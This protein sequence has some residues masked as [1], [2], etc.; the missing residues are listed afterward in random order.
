MAARTSRYPGSDT[1]GVPASLTSTTRAPCRNLATRSSRLEPSL[2][3]CSE[4]SGRCTPSC[5]NRPAV[6]RVSSAAIT[7]AAASASRA[8]GERSP[9]LP[10]GVATTSIRPGGLTIIS[11]AI[12]RVLQGIQK[13]APP[14]PDRAT[15]S[16]SPAPQTASGRLGLAAASL[17]ALLVLGACTTGPVDGTGPASADRAERLEKQGNF[18]AAAQMYERLAAQNPRARQSRFRAGRGACLARRQPPRRRAAHARCLQCG[19]HAGAGLR[20]R[21]AARRNRHGARAVRRRV[22]RSVRGRRTGQSRAGPPACSAPA[23]TWRCARGNRSRR[24][25]PASR[26][27]ASPTTDANRNSARRDLLSDLRGA[28]DRGLRIDPAAAR[29]PLVRG[30]LEIGQIARQRGPQ[31]HGRRGRDR[32]LAHPLPGA[33]GRHHCLRRD[34][35]AGVARASGRR[36][37]RNGIHRAA[38]AA[39]GLECRCRPTDSRWLPGLDVAATRSHSHPPFRFTTPARSPSPPRCRP[40]SPEGAGFVVGPLTREQVQQAAEQRPGVLP[41]AAA[42]Q[43]RRR[44][45]PGRTAFPVRAGARGRSAPDR[46]PV[47]CRRP[48]ARAGVGAYGRM[49]HTRGHGVCR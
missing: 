45:L 44:C 38:A 33:S 5:F 28:I 22:A 20:T 19:G 14:D 7:S 10:M 18:T 37:S 16:P 42:Q 30:W 46:A 2:C 34:H 3:S 48:A 1:S 4:I 32:S 25:V 11:G 6:W 21:V 9:R 41:H 8:R 13:L 26:A 36:N 40:R 39:V 24:C 12:S 47:E 31:S 17:L 15:R 27:S 23:R 29:E 43:P 49:G 35:R